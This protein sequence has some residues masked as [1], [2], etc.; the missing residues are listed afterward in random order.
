MTLMAHGLIDEFH[1]LLTPVAVGRGQH[2]FEHIDGAPALQ[3][4]DVTRFS[5]GVLVLVYTPT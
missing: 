2:M 5:N 3:L 1:L 4:A